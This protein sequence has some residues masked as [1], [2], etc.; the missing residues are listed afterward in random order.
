MKVA[1]N[2]VKDI[3]KYYCDQLCSI[4]DK[5]EAN[6]MILILFEH[7]FNIDRVKMAL[8]P[9]IRLSESEML[10]IHFAVKD[11][12]KNKP[13]Q[14]IIGE[15]EFCELKFKVNESVLI[16]RPETSEMVYKIV[17]KTTG[18]QDNEFY[19]SRNAESRLSIL[20]I[21]TGS[22]CIAISLAKLFP[23]AQVYA[24]D[25]SEDALKVARENSINNKVNITFIQ[26]DILSLNN[27]IENKFD[28]IVSNPPYVR[29]L[30]KAEMRDNV[31][32]WEPD[33]ALFVSNED[34]L[35]FY[36]KILEFAKSHLKEDGEIW[37]EI[38][39]YLGKEMTELCKECGFSNVKIH[40]DFRGKERIMNLK[41]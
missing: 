38:N 28:I 32:K 40:K 36:R 20:D 33:K 30:E 29:E 11:L 41:I 13:I 25:I 3:R 37:F 8:E 35:I 16:P 27:Y 5:D 22:G 34:P 39:E 9:D 2:L 24:L 12:L 7:Y 23:E 26:D 4:Y 17:N 31:L 10:K 6:A 15:T 18:Q 19:S 21:G 1:S 14:Y